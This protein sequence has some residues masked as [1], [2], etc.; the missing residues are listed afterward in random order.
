MALLYATVAAAGSDQA[1]ATEIISR[2]TQVTGGDGSVGVR[3]SLASKFPC[4]FYVYNTHA[5]GGVKVYP[6]V[7][8]DINDGT[9]DAAIVMEGK[10]LAVFVC[11]DGT[12]WAGQFTADT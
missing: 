10:T 1:G 7:G 6:H 2:Y 8:G 12:T 11:M 3:L 4:E 9:T 5:T